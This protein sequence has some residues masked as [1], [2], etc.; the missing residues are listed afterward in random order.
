[1]GVLF[2][3]GDE[4]QRTA[5]AYLN[6]HGIKSEAWYGDVRFDE[7]IIMRISSSEVIV[8][9]LPVSNDSLTLNMSYITEPAPKLEKIISLIK[10]QTLVIGGKFD[11]SLKSDLEDRKIKYID[12]FEDES[13]QI[14][15]A[16]LSA[17]G[18]IQVAMNLSKA[19]IFNS[20]IAIIGY[21]RIGKLLSQKLFVLGADVT[22]CARKNSDLA[23]AEGFGY[24]SFPIRQSGAS[25]SLS[26]LSSGYNII[27]NTAPSQILDEDFAA[28]LDPDTLIIELASAPFGIDEKIVSRYGLNYIKALGIP[29]K[30]YPISAGEITG[31]A[32][33]SILEKEGIVL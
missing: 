7:D 31:K 8:L 4:R 22:V 3:G 2:L 30:Y 25:S 20:K 13:F 5:C 33:M 14:K 18:A 6:E 17:E 9:P 11:R 12:Y 29:G 16:V 21:G 10:P 15:N 28:R 1:M 24:K 26:E 23:W 27:F 32:V 19:S